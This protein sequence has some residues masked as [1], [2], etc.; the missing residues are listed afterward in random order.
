[1]IFFSGPR[2]P[3]DTAPDEVPEDPPDEIPELPPADIPE[4]SPDS[5]PDSQPPEQPDPDPRMSRWDCIVPFTLPSH[6]GF[7]APPAPCP[8]TSGRSH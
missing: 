7:S 4:S 6:T 1:M 8:K 2:Q 3:P 5:T